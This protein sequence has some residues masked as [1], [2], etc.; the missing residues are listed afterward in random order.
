MASMTMSKPLGMMAL[1]SAVLGRVGLVHDHQVGK[2]ILAQNVQLVGVGI[3]DDHAARPRPAEQLGQDDAGGACAEHE[4]GVAEAGGDAVH[5]VDRAGG[6]LG[7]G[8]LLKGQLVAE[9]EHLVVVDEH[10]LGK[11]AGHVAA[12]GVEVLAVQGL[13]LRHGSQ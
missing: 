3:G 10:I 1:I 9:G 13:S 11:A 7:K 4:D 6:G 5:A 8:G 2:A 12:V